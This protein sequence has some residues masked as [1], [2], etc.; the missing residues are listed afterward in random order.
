MERTDDSTPRTLSLHLNS[1][2]DE[3]V[4]NQR[5][6]PFRGI[7]GQ[8]ELICSFVLIHAWLQ[9]VSNNKPVLIPC[10]SS[11]SYRLNIAQQ[12]YSASTASCATCSSILTLLRTPCRHSR[13]FI[14]LSIQPDMRLAGFAQRNP[15]HRLSIV[16]T[17]AAEHNV[18]SHARIQSR[19][20][21]LLE[22][23][24]EP[25][26]A[27]GSRAIASVERGLWRLQPVKTTILN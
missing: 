11:V 8:R 15:A 9:T 22:H 3:R 4:V 21:A 7:H 1:F 17:V 26:C 5:D 16:R 23:R 14:L 20:G 18:P 13:P 2:S 6:L 12:S 27:R 10:A 24:S 25:S 19:P